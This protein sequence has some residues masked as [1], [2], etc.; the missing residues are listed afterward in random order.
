MRLLAGVLIIL[1][2]LVA[3]IMAAF[4][5][6]GIANWDAGAAEGSEFATCSEGNY[7]DCDN[8]GKTSFF[9]TLADVSFSG[10]DGAPS[11]VNVLWLTTM[12][13]LL[14]AAILLIVTS[15][16]PLTSA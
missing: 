2:V 13:L 3:N 16:I 14:T 1:F 15:F 7:T 5:E 11:I 10:F 12:G 4:I 6:S 8:V 9:T